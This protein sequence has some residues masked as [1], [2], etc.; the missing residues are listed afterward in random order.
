MCPSLLSVPQ[1][2]QPECLGNLAVEP[3]DFVEIEAHSP[4]LS[5]TV[6][7]VSIVDILTLWYLF[8]L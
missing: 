1:S 6:P 8:I 3:I 7:Q 5:N 4:F 2:Q